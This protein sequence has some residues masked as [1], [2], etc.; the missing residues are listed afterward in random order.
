M[1]LNERDRE[2]M[3]KSFTERDAQMQLA[4]PNMRVS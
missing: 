3:K 2:S 4:L 1:K